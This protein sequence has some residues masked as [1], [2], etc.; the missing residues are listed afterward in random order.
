MLAPGPRPRPGAI[1]LAPAL[2]E[3]AIAS[4]SAAVDPVAHALLLKGLA[5]GLLPVGLVAVDR[6]LLA[7]QQLR[8]LPE[9]GLRGVRGRQAVDDPSP[10]RPDVKLHP[11]VPVLALAGLLHLRIPRPAGVL[12]RA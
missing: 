4:R 12:R 11:E 1:D 9:V 3:V 5:V 7:V 10:I 8:E 6:A 2:A